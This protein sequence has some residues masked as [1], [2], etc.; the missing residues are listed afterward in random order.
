M[1]DEHEMS[2]FPALFIPSFFRLTLSSASTTKI[3][4]KRLVAFVLRFNA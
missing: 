2:G 3:I 4:T 1:P